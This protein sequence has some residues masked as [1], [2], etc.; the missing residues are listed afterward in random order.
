M[1]CA[2]FDAIYDVKNVPENLSIVKHFLALKQGRQ[3]E[4]PTFRKN[5]VCLSL[6]EIFPVDHGASFVSVGMITSEGMVIVTS[7]AIVGVAVSG[8]NGVGVSVA[9]GV[10]VAVAAKVAGGDG[11]G[12]TTNVGVEVG[13]GVA[14]RVGG[15]RG[16]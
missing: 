3:P 10:L 14:V 16:T 15:S 5:R 1:F 8:G 6:L 9:G 2:L 13:G 7:T 11:V 12:I 4:S